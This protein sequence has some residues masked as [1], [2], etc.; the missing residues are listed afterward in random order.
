MAG[1]GT[2][3]RDSCGGEP[4]NADLRAL[5]EQHSQTLNDKLDRVTKFIDGDSEPER[6][7]KIRLDR[8]EQAE[9]RRKVWVGAAIVAGI[10]AVATSI[11]N[12]VSG[13]H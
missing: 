13:H 11:W 1:S 10:G 8:L 7:A 12:V 6:G 3:N 5:I 4:T 2:F 9:E